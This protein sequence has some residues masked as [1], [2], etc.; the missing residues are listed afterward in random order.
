[1]ENSFYSGGFLVPQG[2]YVITDMTVM[3]YRGH[4]GDQPEVLGCM[5]SFVPLTD[6]KEENKKSQFYGFG[7]QAH[8]SF[9]PNPQHGKGI[10][11]IP[12]APATGFNESTNWNI[13]RKSFFD[14]NLPQ[15]IVTDRVDPLEGTWVYLQ[16]IPEPEER[17]SFNTNSTA[18]VQQTA[19]AD[20]KIAVIGQILD[21]G[22]PWEG[23][24]GW[25]AGPVNVGNGHAPAPVAASTLVRPATA[26]LMPPTPQFTPPPPP[27]PP[28]G[29]DTVDIQTHAMNAIADTLEKLAIAGQVAPQRLAVRNDVFN[30]VATKSG[31]QTATAVLTQVIDIPQ[32]FETIL[33]S[34]GYKTQGPL[35]VANK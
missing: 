9:M 22:K 6:P 31:E 21:G 2:Y 14:C 24:G 3:L 11:P 8:K 16:H 33:G 28:A 15:G 5:V 10:V 25:P 27:A 7:S 4:K 23:T 29:M 19:R 34:L 35:V 30:L 20:K 1:M 32:N 26:P 13:F 18:E 17:K 12:G